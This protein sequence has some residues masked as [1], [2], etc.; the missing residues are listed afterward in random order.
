MKI[1]FVD[2]K[3]QYLAINKE[4]DSAIASVLKDA[5][6][7]GGKYV[8]EFEKEFAKFCNAK[9]AVGV[10]SGTDALYLALKAFKIG[11][12]DEVITVPNT[13]I[14]TT[15]AITMTGA[16]V[17]FVDIREDTYTMD[18]NQVEA[19]INS[20]TKAIIP[21]HL[22]GHPA[23]M[24][25][26]MEISK[27]YNLKVIEDAAQAH[28]AMYKGKRVGTLADIACFS[29]F[30]GKNLG[31]YGDAGAIV[32][33]NGEIAEKISMWRNHGRSS[34]KKYEHNFEGFNFRLDALQ[35]A[36]LSV[37]LRYLEKWTENRCN[38]AKIYSELLKGIDSILTPKEDFSAKH[39][40]H[41]FVIRAKERNS[42][43]K[44][45]KEEGISTG[46]HYPIPLHLQRAYQYLN[47][48]KGTYPV[49]ES[50]SSEILSLPIY[51][52][53]TEDQIKYVVNKILNFYKL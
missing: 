1:P 35:A 26:I 4:I 5:A 17:R 38:N 10:G 36:I 51:P 6:F 7:I 34:N 33:N 42:L 21:V 30:P 14:A 28:G 20:K 12:G 53:L 32:T 47:L 48:K 11:D 31:A 50:V 49:T 29:F 43:Q 27:K 13:F 2:L 45:L 44:M 22:Y 40:Y 3:S 39:V 24:D 37:K 23:N 41:L 46:I 8:Q 16:A 52:E 18:F 19:Y 25:P 9:F 15:E